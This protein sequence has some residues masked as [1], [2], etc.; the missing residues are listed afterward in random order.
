VE[1]IKIT[2]AMLRTYLWYRGDDDIY[3]RDTSVRRGAPFEGVEVPDEAW[4]QISL[5]LQSLGMV[6]RG[7]ASPAFAAEVHDSLERLAADPE[8]RE[9]ILRIARTRADVDTNQ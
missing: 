3:A 2:S 9:E 4:K 1:H 8:A 5:L 7:L 6:E